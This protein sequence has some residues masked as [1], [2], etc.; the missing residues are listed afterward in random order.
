MLCSD[1]QSVASKM[2]PQLLLALLTLFL[3]QLSYAGCQMKAM[4]S[5]FHLAPC[6]PK[7]I[8]QH[9]RYGLKTEHD[10]KK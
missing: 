1:I 9:M 8:K 5:S 6:N 2:R 7:L 4:V 10:F 3:V